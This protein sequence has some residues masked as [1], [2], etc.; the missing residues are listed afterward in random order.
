VDQAM[1]NGIDKGQGGKPS[2]LYQDDEY[3]V[4][5]QKNKMLNSLWKKDV[6]GAHII[7]LPS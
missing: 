3:E 2:M 5:K 1:V 6:P 7:D 4:T